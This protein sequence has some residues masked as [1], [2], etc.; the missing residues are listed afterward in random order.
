MPCCKESN[1]VALHHVEDLKASAVGFGFDMSWLTD[2]IS[3][4]GGDVLSLVVEAV[5]GGFNKDLVVD[6]LDK[7]GPFVLE[8]LVNLLNAKK[9]HAGVAGDF[10]VGEEVGAF[11]GAILETL[12]KKWLPVILE[13][14]GDQ[15]VGLVVQY[16]L[17]YL[18]K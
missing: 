16:L 3:R 15:I 5:R 7:F 8:M 2:L 14:Y 11:D 12:L 13:K 18:K 9:L 10:V 6:V 17:D 4:F 1:V